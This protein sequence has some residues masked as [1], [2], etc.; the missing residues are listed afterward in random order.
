MSKRWK[1]YF[2]GYNA[3]ESDWLKSA[4]LHWGFHE[5]LYGNIISVCPPPARIIDVGCGP[6]WSAIYLAS[7]GY[8]VVGLDNEQSLVVLANENA[9][10]LGSRARFICGDAFDLLSLEQQFDL[11]YSC[12]VLE[13]FDRHVTIDLLKQQANCA[14]YVLIQIP[15]RFTAYTGEITDERIYS[16]SELKGIVRDAGLD[17]KKSFGYGELSVTKIHF[18][19]RQILPRAMWRFLQNMGYSFALA[20]IG[21]SSSK[22]DKSN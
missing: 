18:V 15:S 3:F 7:L 19:L 9:H 13:H 11:A 12:G 20:V 5:T 8:E 2:S 6:G 1:E 17:V 10:R 4:V 22:I 14:K 21:S 16:I